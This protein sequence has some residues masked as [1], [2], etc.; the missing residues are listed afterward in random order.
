MIPLAHRLQVHYKEKKNIKKYQMMK[1]QTQHALHLV[2]KQ[3]Q[4]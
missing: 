4:L 3:N 2:A 1:N